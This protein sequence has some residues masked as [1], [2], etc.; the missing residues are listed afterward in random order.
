M[1]DRKTPSALDYV[2]FSRTILAL[3]MTGVRTVADFWAHSV[4]KL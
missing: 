3:V 1:L 4:E 2:E